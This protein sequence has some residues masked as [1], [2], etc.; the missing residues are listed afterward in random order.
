VSAAVVVATVSCGGSSPRAAGTP[1]APAG[2]AVAA[3][4]LDLTLT[5]GVSDHVTTPYSNNVCILFERTRLLCHLTMPPGDAAKYHVFMNIS[6]YKGPG[7]YGAKEEA[8]SGSANTA[9]GL[10][11]VVGGIT[12]QSLP[13]VDGRVVFTEGDRAVGT[14]GR[15]AAGTITAD[16]QPQGAGAVARQVHISGMFSTA[17]NAGA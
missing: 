8:P 9:T 4:R 15:E 13:A 3:Q 10:R 11:L 17:L 2:S 6:P 5:G 12:G 14:S 16:F 1:A 7:A